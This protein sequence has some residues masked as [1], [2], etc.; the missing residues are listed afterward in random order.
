MSTWH[1]GKSFYGGGLVKGVS[2][3]EPVPLSDELPERSDVVIIGGGF[4][5]CFTA[6]YLTERG[7]S[8]TL[9]E[10]GVVAGEAS[11][12]SIGWIDAQYLAPVKME[13]IAQAKR[14]WAGTE[15]QIGAS[16]GYDRCG[17]LSVFR[18]YAERDMAE[19]WLAS[20]RG[21][22]GVDAHL[23]T[24]QGAAQYLPQGA[25]ATYGGLYQASDARAE[26]RLAAPRVAIA[27]R[28]R[29]ARIVQQCAVRQIELQNGQV[30]AVHTERGAVQC[31]AVLVA[32]GVWSPLLARSLGLALPQLQAFG[33]AQRIRP[34]CA[35]PTASAWVPQGIYRAN[36]DGSYTVG[37]VNGAAPLTPSALLQLRQF[38]PAVRA[39]WSQI[40]PVLSPGTFFHDLRNLLPWLGQGS[41][42]ERTRIY[43]P[44]VRETVLADILKRLA[45]AYPLFKSAQ[46][47][48]TWA[49]ALV[50]TPDNMPVISAVNA[51]PGLYLGTG[52]YYGLT[53]APAAATALADLITGEPTQI[54]LHPY[55][56]ERFSD[57]SVLSFQP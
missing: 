27:A 41:P 14:Q 20:V 9:C 23:V 29:G 34:T 12:R 32:G 3:A 15:A 4:I 25:D 44:Q 46:V 22:P 7:Y 31:N 8:V 28:S 19:Q 21:L 10:K 24:M 17:L 13:L 39:M 38:L 40:D 42:Y 35:G 54:D 51:I 56:Y 5:G 55:R 16:V 45:A 50:S 53:M 47:E 52:F 11:G 49:G 1:I 30:H 6:L 33:S 57:G 36:G 48:E 37:A 18:S 2:R 43:Q 26:P